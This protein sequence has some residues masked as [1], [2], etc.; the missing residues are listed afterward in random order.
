MLERLFHLQA[1]QTTWRREVIGGATT[2]LTMAYI[3]FVQPV[4]LASAGMEPGAVLVATCLATAVATFAMAFLANYPIALAPA[5]GHNVYFTYT[6]V[7]GLGYPWPQ[8]LGA[9]FISGVLFVL[10]SFVGLRAK[11]LDTLP[12]ALKDAI[13]AGIGLLIAAVGLQW[14]G[15]VVDHEGTLVGL[16]DLSSPQVL[17]ALLGL[18]LMSVLTVLGFRAAVLVGML[19]TAGVALSLGMAEYQGIV[20]PVPSLAPTFLALDVPGVLK[21]GA[22]SIIFVFFFLDLFDTV[23]TLTGVSREAGLLRPDGTLPRGRQALLADALGTVSGAL[24]GTSTVTSYVESAA[25]VSA[26]ARTGLSSLVTGSLFLLALFF[27]PLVSLIGGGIRV[28]ELTLY[29]IVA[30]ALIL[31]GCLLLRSLRHIRWEDPSE[32]IPAFL[33][34]LLMPM[35]FSITEGIAFGFIAYTAL[36]AAGGKL[37]EVPPLIAVFAF[38]FL[39]RYALVPVGG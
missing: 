18:A 37:R 16:G 3:I 7:L 17:L 8:A 15:L 14:S 2:F 34:V 26:G 24:L 39:L 29:P 36:K 4:V 11:L 12:S 31:V 32:A 1:H 33:T 22:V 25:G 21:A 19:G 9:V 27:T 20:G 28:G 10:T 30:P 35:T 5:M 13:A 6:V 23:G 38:L